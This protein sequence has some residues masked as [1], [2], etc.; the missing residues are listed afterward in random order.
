LLQL[1]YVRN[2]DR[3]GRTTTTT[4]YIRK[5]VINIGRDA[6]ILITQNAIRCA[7]GHQA[8]VRGMEIG[9]ILLT[10]DKGIEGC[11]VC[12]LLWHDNDIMTWVSSMP[13]WDRPDMFIGL[14]SCRHKIG[15]EP[16]IH[17]HGFPICISEEARTGKLREWWRQMIRSQKVV[18]SKT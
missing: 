16:G 6:T 1:L 17:E 18:C 3:R 14:R 8:L 9:I 5:G 2:T 13:R 15:F 4:M 11:P 10:N 7:M 12:L